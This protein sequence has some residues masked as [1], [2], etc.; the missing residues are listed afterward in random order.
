MKPIIPILIRN[1][2]LFRTE[3]QELL[4]LQNRRERDPDCKVE[5]I[6]GVLRNLYINEGADWEGRGEVQKLFFAA[7]IAA[8]EHFIAGWKAE[9]RD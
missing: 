9:R 3:G 5:D 2:W 7:S 6:E 8:H 4:A 1:Y